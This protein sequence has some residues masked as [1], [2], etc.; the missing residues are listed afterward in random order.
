MP[1]RVLYHSTAR[2]NR[3]SILACGL[4]VEYDQTGMDAVFLSDI[5]T[6]SAQ[7]DLWQV[8]VD[9]LELIED[10]TVPEVG[11]WFMC[12]GDIPA[13]KLTLAVV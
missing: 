11:N 4:L 3:E 9:G 12:F 8:D 6:S 13:R 10:N 5:Q 1:R 7:F 2:E